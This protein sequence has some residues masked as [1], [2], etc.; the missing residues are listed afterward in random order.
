MKLDS[1]ERILVSIAQ[2]GVKI[3]RLGWGG[4][5]PTKTIWESNDVPKM[6]RLFGNEDQPDRDLLD[7]IIGKCVEIK[8]I[9]ELKR[10]VDG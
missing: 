5:M 3:S 9:E 10:Y 8:S 4:L 7:S 1:S 6:V 2:T